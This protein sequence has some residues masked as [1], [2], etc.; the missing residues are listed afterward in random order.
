MDTM[1]PVAVQRNASEHDPPREQD[2][3][4]PTISEPSAA[5]PL[6]ELDGGEPPARPPKPTIPLASVHRKA[7]VG[8]L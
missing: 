2:R 5:M 3:A 6:A 8:P 1:P 7:P 4:E